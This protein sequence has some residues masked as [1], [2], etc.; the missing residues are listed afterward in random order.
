MRKLL[1]A[2]L[3][4]AIAPMAQAQDKGKSDFTAG[5]EFRVR[6][7]WMMN[8]KGNKDQKPSNNNSILQRFKLGVNFKATEKLSAHAT[9]IQAAA[10]G[11]PDNENIGDRGNTTAGLTDN[12][13]RNFMSVQ[14]AYGKWMIS[15]DFYA[16]FGRMGFAFGDGSIMS[17]NDWEQQ[18]YSFD[19][20]TLNYEAE[21]GK[22][23]GFAFKYR[24]YGLS[25][26]IG[27]GNSTISDPE[28]NAYGVVFDLKTKPEWLTTVNAHV[29]QDQ[30]DTVW[31]KTQGS[32]VNSM[33]NM[34]ITRAGFNAGAA[35]MGMLDVKAG[36][37]RVMG[38]VSGATAG[39]G[40]VADANK[41][42]VESSMMQA[43]V[44][45]SMPAL[46]GSRWFVGYHQDSGTGAGE[47][48]LKTYDGYFTDLADGAGK[49]QLIA[50]G[51]LTYIDLGWTLKPTDTT[52]V[53][54]KF[55]MYSKTNSDDYVRANVNGGGL[56]G[57]GSTKVG[58][59]A[60]G[61]EVNV[62]AEHHYDR[63]F[64]ILANLGYFMPGSSMKDDTINKKDAIS[65]LLVQARMMF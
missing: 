16:K 44:G 56:F 60:I 21:F 10:W 23:T 19:G 53:G 12:H 5:G 47:T 40:D 52:D 62:W 15:D 14:E 27:N 45:F 33:G 31:G 54:V 38:K 65:Q 39:T 25:T 1:A 41:Q 11:Q 49:M 57:A 64:S 28:H 2:A 30:G 48:K 34:S 46:M 4:L 7:N 22:F 43:E 42:D 63:N 51:N 6:D 9:M 20:M 8:E 13:E 59:K 35:F 24:E 36:Y 58:E 29:I 50:W 32:T 37:E 26:A 61:N 18:P 55:Y 3:L 17:M